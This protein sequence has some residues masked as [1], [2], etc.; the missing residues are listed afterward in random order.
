MSIKSLATSS[1][2]SN[3]GVVKAQTAVVVVTAPGAPTIGTATST[4]QTTATSSPGGITAYLMQAGSGTISVTGL[5]AGTSY[6]FTVTATNSAGT[7]SASSASNSITTT[8]SSIT[9]SGG[10]ETTSGGYKYHT[11]LTSGSLT[12]TSVPN[13][14]VMEYLVVGGGAGG[15]MAYNS[16]NQTLGGPGGGAG[17][18]LEY[19][20]GATPGNAY[21]GPPIIVSSGQTLTVTVGAGGPAQTSSVWSYNVT[22]G[23]Y[24]GVYG[25]NMAIT[26]YAGGSIGGYASNHFPKP[27]GSCGGTVYR[28]I[29]GTTTTG[30]QSLTN[31][32]KPQ[33]GNDGF[34]VVPGTSTYATR[35]GGA[36]PNN[37]SSGR[38]WSVNGTTYAAGGTV[39]TNA[40][41]GAGTA[42]ASNTGNGGGGAW[43]NAG[44]VAYSYN[45]G[46]GGSGIVIIRYVYP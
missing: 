27:G 14:F 45:G 16:S 44:G 39:I 23:N 11:F 4:G 21:I 40:V 7:S 37:D 35:G 30:P 46:A 28:N 24:S 13:N 5:T 18:Y 19:T 32:I 43:S 9:V 3:V 38:T 31:I 34:V 17:G 20:S 42:G 33:Q 41:N 36:G 1:S 29:S 10:T 8:S 26:A 6:T 2:I 12:I 25:P 15:G 22:G